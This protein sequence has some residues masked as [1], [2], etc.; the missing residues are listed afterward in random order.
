MS[1]TALNTEVRPPIAKK[2]QPWW[3]SKRSRHTGIALAVLALIA[4]VVWWFAFRPYVATDDARVAMTLV[5]VAPSQVG[6]RIEK[7][8]VEEG[9][10]VK[11]GDVLL[12][13]D[14][15]VAQANYVKAKAKADLNQ[16]EFER[17]ERL[18]R[19]GSATAQARDLAQ[20]NAAVAKAELALAEVA[21]ENTTLVSPFDGIVVQKLTETGNLLEPGQ[22]ALVIADTEHPWISANI[23]ETAVGEVKPGQSVHIT[24]DEGGELEGKVSEVRSAAASQFAL[25]PTDSGAGNYTKVVQRIPIKVIPENPSAHNLR[26][27]ES[28]EIKIRV[29]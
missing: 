14:H 7:L 10:R 8:L 19:E 20:S 25:I 13:I 23:E 17:M 26:A 9:S 27:G 3:K 5:R 4:T 28:V 6:G 29:K 21:L 16:K 18:A 22:T 11:K 2:K 1:A 12:E 24:V 15:R